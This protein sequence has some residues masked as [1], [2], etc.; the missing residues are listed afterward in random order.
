MFPP[1]GR[2]S[3]ALTHGLAAPPLSFQEPHSILLLSHCLGAVGVHSDH[4]PTPHSQCFDDAQYSFLALRAT[5]PNLVG[6]R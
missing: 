1:Q 3:L 6:V 4:L 2:L 5:V